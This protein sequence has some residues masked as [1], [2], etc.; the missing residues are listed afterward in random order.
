MISLNL[1]L[2]ESKKKPLKKLNNH[3]NNLILINL[4]GFRFFC[5]ENRHIYIIKNLITCP[6]KFSYLT[7][8]RCRRALNGRI[9]NFFRIAAE[10]ARFIIVMT[11]SE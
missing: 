10:Y 4:S 2:F 5:F 9:F 11:S 7:F 6:P 8:L 1:C 3:L